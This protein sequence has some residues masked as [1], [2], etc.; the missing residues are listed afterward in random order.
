MQPPSAP[1]RASPF[2]ITTDFSLV[3]GGPLFQILRRLHL[4]DDALTLLKRRIVI[5]SLAAWAPLLLLSA[6]EG[7]LWGG[8]VEVPFL[9][10]ISTHIR[11]LIGLPLLIA[12]E[13][14]VHQ[15]V[16]GL[17]EQFFERDLIPETARDRF[18]EAIASAMRLRDSVI[19]ELLLVAFVYAVGVTVIW[20]QFIAL[21]VS[22]WYTIPGPGGG[23]LTVA[24]LWFCYASLPISQFL[25]VRW[26]FR[27]F[28]WARFLWQVSRIKLRILPIHPDGVG[29]L[30]FLGGI[31]HALT[32]LAATHGV[33]LAAVLADAILLAGASLADYKLEI[34]VIV[35]FMLLMVL[36]PLLVFTPQLAAA[37][38]RGNREYGAFAQS[39]ARGFDAKWLRDDPPQS[40]PLLGTADIQSMAD[41]NNV[42]SVVRGMQIVPVTKQAVTQVTL[43]T[44]APLAPL[45]LT[46]MPLEELLKVLLGVV[47]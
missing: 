20:R 39:Y 18:S 31:A 9:R 29:G 35:A 45:L 25:L 4:E 3:I 34:A 28:I 33:L 10:D 5:I 44:L 6:V 2:P 36:G 23:V 30:A 27:L 22:T 24:G 46:M 17:V 47:M 37:K 14:I 19:A 16:R 1:N 40:E 41:L 43:A 26:Y 38:R 42:V 8:E 32:L 15:R 7:R 13:L 21:D 11:F 12:A